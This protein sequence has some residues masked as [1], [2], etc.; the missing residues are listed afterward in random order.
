MKTAQGKT[1]PW[2]LWLV[3]V[4]GLAWNLFGCFDYFMSKTK[5]DAWLAQAGMSPEQIDHFNAMPIWMTAVWAVGVWG[6][7]AGTIL[8]L[9]RSRFA[10]PVFAASLAAYGIS[11]IY[12][13]FIN[14]APG[15]TPPLMIMQGVI[16]AGC[17]FFFWY[18]QTQQRA[19]LLK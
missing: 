15:M 17:V 8:L 11:L 12:G 1:T 18:A 2:H 3:G 5:G 9:L 14:P 16:L 10:A 19:G 13:F 7:L 4:M 6:A